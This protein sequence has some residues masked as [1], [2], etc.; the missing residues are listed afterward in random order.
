MAPAPSELAPEICAL[1]L[2]SYSP[3]AVPKLEAYLESACRGDAPYNFDAVRTLVKLYQLFPAAAAA[4]A[5][6]NIGY[7]CLLA[8]LYGENQ[9]DL[10]ALQYMIPTATQK[11][12]PCASVNRCASLFRACLF[13]DF[14]QTF[15]STLV[16]N[17]DAVV[18]QVCQA[19][20]PAVRQSILA[21][22]AL[23]YKEAPMAVV[24]AALGTD[25]SVSSEISSSPV[26][27]S[28]TADTVTFVATPDNSKR[29][30]VFQEG[31]SFQ[32]VSSLLHKMTQ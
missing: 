15:N 26:V 6:K 29:Q 32:T 1:L 13:A 30:R 24:L 27:A 2:K 14:W 10:L 19:A 17:S 25:A 8:L 7:A 23:T 20:V 12:E 16:N 18:Q 5:K 21:V 31:V 4:N 28:V 9:D 22:V 3:A 11:E